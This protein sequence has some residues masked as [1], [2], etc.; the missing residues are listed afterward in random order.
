MSR[1]T[2]IAPV[3]EGATSE[4]LRFLAGGRRRD[5]PTAVRAEAFE[6]MIDRCGG[7]CR[8]WWARRDGRCVAASLAVAGPGRV[9]MLSHS[10]LAA[11]GVDGG[12]VAAVVERAGR[13]AL[14]DGLAFIQSLLAPAL[15]ADSEMLVSAGFR[16]LAELLYM[17]LDLAERVAAKGEERCT[18]RSFRRYTEEE[19]SSV[20]E[21]T[22]EQSF[23]CPPLRGLRPL[24]DVIEGHKA[25]GVFSPRS[26]WIA[27]VEH[28]PAGCILVNDSTVSPGEMDLVYM[29][30][31]REFR[32]RGI[33]RA[34]VRRA[35]RWARRRKRRALTVAV[36]T[37][38]T[39][40]KRIYDQSGFRETFRRVAYILP[41]ESLAAGAT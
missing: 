28:R 41:R 23:D 3:P 4:T 27:G 40:A 1:E 2:E 7:R 10:P 24:S 14:G 33:G 19:L 17:R 16:R 29:G 35:A 37:E 11:P 21:A 25:S 38:N 6:R 18:W 8:F 31:A 20:I 9:G 32:G 22:Y 5:I 34:M 26:W 15:R 30:V 13:Q 39:Y 12:C 36:D